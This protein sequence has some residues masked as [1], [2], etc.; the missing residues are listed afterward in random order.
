M[1]VKCLVLPA[2]MNERR[3]THEILQL[4][5]C[6]LNDTILSVK[7][8]T[9]ATQVADLRPAHHK[10]IN[11]EPS[12]GQNPRHARQ[13]TR[14]ILHKAVQ[15]VPKRHQ[16]INNKLGESSYDSER[17]HFLNGCRLGGGVLYRMLVTA[18]SAE[19]ERGRS[20]AGSGGG[21]VRRVRL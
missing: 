16:V 3:A 17:T 4:P 9:H 19:R 5:S 14:L 2:T 8:D 18:S 1:I 15:D 11:I 21:R 20:V 13:H 6:L 10:R 12:S 7:D